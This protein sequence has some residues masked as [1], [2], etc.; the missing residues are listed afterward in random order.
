MCLFFILLFFG[1][2]V[3][4]I[5]W[6]IARPLRFDI[7]FDS[8]ILPVLGLIFLPWTTLM[9]VTV[10]M[11]GVT[12]WDWFWMALGLIGDVASYSSS[13]YSNRNQIPGYGR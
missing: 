12:G 9:Y 7:L 10:G 11:N 1:P 4:T 6:W 3:G 8:W 2:R 5:V 13:A